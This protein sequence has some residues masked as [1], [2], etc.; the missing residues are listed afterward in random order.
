MG[1]SLIAIALFSFR[2]EIVMKKCH[3]RVVQK[4]YITKGCFYGRE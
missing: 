2:V 4:W 3:N 1:L